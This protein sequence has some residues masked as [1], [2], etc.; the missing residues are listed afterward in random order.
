MLYYIVIF[1]LN[2]R[3]GYNNKNVPIP[4]LHPPPGQCTFLE[5]HYPWK[6]LFCDTIS[7][8]NFLLFRFPNAAFVSPNFHRLD[9]LSSD[10]SGNVWLFVRNSQSLSF[11]LLLLSRIH[12]LFMFSFS[13]SVP[14]LI[15]G[16]LFLLSLS[17]PRSLSTSLSPLSL[18]F[19]LSFL[20]LS[21]FLPLFL[22][23]SLCE[24]WQRS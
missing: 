17:C 4:H 7:Q 16:P 15:S 10:G 24:N 6:G 5:S 22:S 19:Y 11:L 3:V 18:S 13:C 2:E 12:F 23:L 21:L 9:S 8:L 14:L 20:S 1:S